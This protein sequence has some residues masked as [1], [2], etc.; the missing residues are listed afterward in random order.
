M[1]IGTRYLDRHGSLSQSCPLGE[2]IAAE[3]ALGP[4][5]SMLSN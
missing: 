1:S 2:D 4:M 3:S 5:Q